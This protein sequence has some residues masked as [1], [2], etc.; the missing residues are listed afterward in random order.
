MSKINVEVEGSAPLLMN[1]FSIVEGRPIRKKHVYNPKDE[2][3]RK[4]YRT[5]EG[6][7]ML[8]ST[9]FKASMI[10]AAT[11]FK[12]SGKKSYKDYVK[13][14]VFI[15]PMEIELNEQEYTIHEEPVVIQRA[16][17]MSWRPRFDKWSCN[18]E[19]EI[20]DESINPETLMEILETAGKY[21]GVGDHRPEYGRFIVKNY[22]IV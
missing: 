4:S 8:P 19:I 6:N 10:K 20:T 13:S 5:S 1:R 3:E 14:G 21:K 15:M 11:D 17:V 18:F 16:R 7:L 22:K 9:H 12:M 2:A